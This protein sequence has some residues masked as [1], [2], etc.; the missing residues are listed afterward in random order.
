MEAFVYCVWFGALG[1]C[2]ALLILFKACR[3]PK[4]TL[5]FPA[6]SI[7]ITTRQEIELVFELL[8]CLHNLDYPA[9]KEVILALDRTPPT[10]TLHEAVQRCAAWG[11]EI[12]VLSIAQ[13]PAGW[14]PRKWAL[15][16]GIEVAKYDWLA[17]TDSD[18][19]PRPLWLQALFLSRKPKTEIILGF[20]PYVF[21]PT[22]L[23]A[24][25]QFET[26]HT[27]FLYGSAAALGFPYWA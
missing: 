19:R 5:A 17:F 25:I 10:A 14:S 6:V 8:E 4:K 24:I 13:N 16:K 15:Q 21:M 27:A 7:I 1:H 23:N 3:K 22:V 11:L 20:S 12:R 18:C 9:P 26:A 2:L